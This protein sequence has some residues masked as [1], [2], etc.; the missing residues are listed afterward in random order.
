MLVCM[1]TTLSLD[2]ELLQEVRRMA[3]ES[4]RTMSEV[5]AD[6]LRVAIHANRSVSERPPVVLKTFKTGGYQPG[7]DPN[8]GASI[9]E[10]MDESD[11]RFR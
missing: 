6:A 10:A 5:V 3:V 7:I 1:R 2:A 4:R 8:R 11:G 9:Y